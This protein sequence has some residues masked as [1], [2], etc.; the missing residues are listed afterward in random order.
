MD[1]VDGVEHRD[2][3]VLTEIR[4]RLDSRA[5]QATVGLHSLA[6]LERA[7]LLGKTVFLG[8]LAIAALATAGRRDSQDI[9]AILEHLDPA[10][11]QAGAA[12]LECQEVR[13]HLASQGL[14]HLD[15]P[16]L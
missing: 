1:K 2:N 6:V 5:R 11:Q 7:E 16:G 10:A 12:S 14:E 13:E 3:G 15:I 8:R 4:G 9:A